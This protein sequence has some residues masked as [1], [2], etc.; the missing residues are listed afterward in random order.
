MAIIPLSP[1]D[2]LPNAATAPTYTGSLSISNSY[3]VSNDGRMFLHF[4]KTGAGAC[5]VT[6]TTPGSVF[7]VAIADVTFTVPATTGDVMF[8]LSPTA[9]YNDQATGLVSFTCSEITGLS[10]AVLHPP[11]AL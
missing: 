9:L 4:K 1:Q 11:V 3:T 2:L 8:P 7:G 6:V 10:V 5:T